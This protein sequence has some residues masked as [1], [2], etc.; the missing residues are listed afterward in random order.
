MLKRDFRAAGLKTKTKYWV[1]Y[2]E[3]TA[4]VLYDTLIDKI[5]FPCDT[6]IY[7][8]PVTV[9]EPWLISTFQAHIS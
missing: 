9:S 7:K 2:D 3:N 6:Y 8:L 4:A 1:Q 5:N